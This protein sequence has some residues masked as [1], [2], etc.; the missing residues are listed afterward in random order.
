MCA[1]YVFA[2]ITVSLALTR[3]PFPV[4]LVYAIDLL[5]AALGCAA[6]VGILEV[7][8]GP[9]AILAAG[10]AAAVAALSFAH[11]ATGSERATL[12]RRSPWRRP[13]MC[14]IALAIAIPLNN[15]SRFGLRPVMVKD[16]IETGWLSRTERWNWYSRVVAYRP[17]LAAPQLWSPSPTTPDTLQVQHAYLN[18]DGAAGT[19]MPHFDG[20]AASID[21]LKY[22]LVNLAYHLPSIESRRSS[23]SA[24]GAMC[25]R[26]ICSASKRSPAS[27]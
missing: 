1:P 6:V 26:R 3:S 10:L 19:T 16:A 27:S 13:L 23:A 22:D 9:T 4:G 2:G 11:A 15:G 24:A 12:S 18:I 17:V 25:W 14:V 5:G 20:T 8:D 21:F 7:L